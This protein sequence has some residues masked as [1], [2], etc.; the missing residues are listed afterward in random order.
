MSRILYSHR[1][2]GVLKQL[3]V[4]LGLEVTL[5]DAKG[6]DILG[7]NESVFEDAAS[8]LAVDLKKSGEGEG[9]VYTFKPK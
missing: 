1:V 2:H 3:V 5:K 4:E 7:A 9:S 8:M 6:E